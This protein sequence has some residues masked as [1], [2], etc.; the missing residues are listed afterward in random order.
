VAGEK[1][2]SRQSGRLE[3]KGGTSGETAVTNVRRRYQ[4]RKERNKLKQQRAEGLERSHRISQDQ[5]KGKKAEKEGGEN[6]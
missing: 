2:V 3:E 1:G 6:M 4:K 5:E